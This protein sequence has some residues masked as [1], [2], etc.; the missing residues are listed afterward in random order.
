MAEKPIERLESEIKMEQLGDNICQML[1]RERG[2]K[3]FTIKGVKTWLPPG[4]TPDG[5]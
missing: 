3:K 2:W 5:N 4:V 1:E